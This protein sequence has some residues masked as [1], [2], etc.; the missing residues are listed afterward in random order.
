MHDFTLSAL[1]AGQM[2]VVHTEEVDASWMVQT[3]CVRS[4]R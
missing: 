2:I 1:Y 4:L 3:A